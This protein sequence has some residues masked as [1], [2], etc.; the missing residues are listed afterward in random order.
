MGKVFVQVTAEHDVNGKIRP[1]TI[2]WEDGRIFEIDRLLDV[3][4]AASLK[5]GGIGM[6]YTCRIYNKQVYLFSNEGKW[7]VERK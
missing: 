3:R 2:K 5:G 1:L 7:F 4:Q 6:R